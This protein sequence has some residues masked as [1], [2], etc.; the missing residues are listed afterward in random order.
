MISDNEST[1]KKKE[2]EWYDG[3]WLGNFPKSWPE[4]ASLGRR[5]MNWNLKDEKEEPVG[6][7]MVVQIVAWRGTWAMKENRGW[8]PFFIQ[9]IKPSTL[10]WCWFPRRRKPL[11]NF[12][13]RGYMGYTP[14]SRDTGLGT[15]IA[16]ALSKYFLQLYPHAWVSLSS[17]N[18]K[19]K[20]QFLYNIVIYFFYPK[21]LI[22]Y[23]TM[24][25]H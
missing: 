20:W 9:Y 3:K 7:C 21:H 10:A 16:K 23:L 12:S 11:S 2:I 5:H 13:H 6:L 19:H 4:N 14:I 1:M 15:K 24:V 22:Y 8:N 17:L 25:R 18:L